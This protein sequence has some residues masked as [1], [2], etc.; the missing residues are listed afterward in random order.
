MRPT[1]TVPLLLAI[2]ACTA[3]PPP[4]P[5]GPL[6]AVA[7]GESGTILLPR[8]RAFDDERP[9]TS[10]YDG[11]TDSTTVAVVTHGG[12]YF[13]WIQRPRIT[14]RFRYAGHHL[15]TVPSDVVFDVRVQH[16]QQ[17]DVSTLEI[18]PAGGGRPVRVSRVTFHSKEDVLVTNLDYAFDVPVAAFARLIRSGTLA[19]TLGGVEATFGGSQMEALR[20]L[21]SRMVPGGQ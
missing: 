18:D 5:P 2:A 11:T 20:D 4:L 1:H 19:L 7:T 9:V 13:L 3:A 14:V 21:A 8:A 12:R 17:P 15:A 10:H 16:P 6:V